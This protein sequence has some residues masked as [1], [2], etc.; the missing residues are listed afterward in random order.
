M[1]VIVKRAANAAGIEFKSIKTA[2]DFAD[3]NIIS[4]YASDSVKELYCAGI[5][6]GMGDNMF[7]PKGSST[8]AQAAKIIYEAFVK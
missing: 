8:R 2:E 6:S 5:I 3:S 7:N 4:D 1:A